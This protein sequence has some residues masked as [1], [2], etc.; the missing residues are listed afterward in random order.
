[1]AFK[2]GTLFLARKC[3]IHMSL[4]A[5]GISGTISWKIP[6]GLFVKTACSNNQVDVNWFIFKRSWMTLTSSW[7]TGLCGPIFACYQSSGAET[8]IF[9]RIIRL[10]PLAAGTLALLS[11]SRHQHPWHVLN[12]GHCLPHAGKASFNAFT[13]ADCAFGEIFSSNF[14]HSSWH[15]LLMTKR[16]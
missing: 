1:M 12:T 4:R 5:P 2:L 9:S 15:Y 16:R 10:M 8:R 14:T 11:P 7:Y 3:F 13:K 6:Y